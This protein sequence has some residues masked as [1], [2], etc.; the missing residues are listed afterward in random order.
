[1][2][3]SFQEVSAHLDHSLKI[4]QEEIEQQAQSALTIQEKVALEEAANSI[5]NNDRQEIADHNW[6]K[7]EVMCAIFSDCSNCRLLYFMHCYLRKKTFS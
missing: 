6:L 4:A 2:D 7:K 5:N 1:M 3:G